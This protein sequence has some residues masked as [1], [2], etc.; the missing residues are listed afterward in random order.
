[1]A[2][3]QSSHG[4]YS[5]MSV[6]ARAERRFPDHRVDASFAVCIPVYELRIK[7]TELGE[8]NL[9]TAS[10]FLL[11]LVN[12]GVSQPSELS[13][14]LGI[15]SEHVAA[16]A[17][18]LLGSALVV[19]S[20]DK[21]ICITGKGRKVLAEGG[22]TLRPRNRHPKIPYDPL[23]RR[24]V[25]V[26]IDR[27]LD[28]DTVR[29]EGLF[30]L[31]T[32]PRRPRISNVGIDDVR[33][34]VQ[35]YGRSRKKAELVA[36][37]DIKDAK[38]RYRDDVV[39]IKLNADNAENSTFA[40][41]RAHQYLE[42]E[43]AALQRLADGG[44]DIVPEEAKTVRSAPWQDSIAVSNE[45]KILL[46]DIDR[47][48]KEVVAIEHAAA[49]AEVSHGTT[50]DDEQRRELAK[51]IVDLQREK[52]EIR[53]QLHGQE[54]K[55]E[56]LGSGETRLIKTEEHRDVLLRAIKQASSELTLVSAWVNARAFDKDLCDLVVAAVMRGVSVRIAWGLG[57]G[58][59]S[60]EAFRNRKK[61]NDALD[62][63]R[64][65]IPRDGKSQ[66]IVKLAETHEKF[67][68]CDD[69]FCAWGSFNWL[70][71]RGERDDGYRRETSFYSERPQDVALWKANANVLFDESK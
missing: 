47:L 28:R 14:L 3:T 60:R 45:E 17:A 10:R 27:L 38:L 63:L 5:Q 26:E 35:T 61:G 58:G 16:A 62:P 13:R 41:Y 39:V 67:I 57:A 52:D 33:E 7:V 2:L 31:P 11:Q 9:S 51:R 36:V 29:S 59:R 12:T 70:S 53:I 37:S 55:L 15:S 25:D 19:Q 6:I 21:G 23:T 50:Q 34:Y 32:S 46:D 49:V 48:D 18:E 71:Y 64:K 30:V 68:I 65:R 40:A 69:Q 42:E 66:L 20:P 54:R 8:D 4:R 1:M 44:L 56:E 22:R 24:I 43:S